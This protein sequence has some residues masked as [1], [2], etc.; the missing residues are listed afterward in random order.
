MNLVDVK[1]IY[2]LGIGGI[3][4]SALARYFLL[5]GKQV[6]GY[7]RTATPLT[8]QLEAEGAL[9]NYE[10]SLRHI[11]SDIDLVIF[12]PAIPSDSRQ[13]EYIRQN[14]IPLYKRARIL[15]MISEGKKVIAVAGTHGKTTVTTILAHIFKRA[16]ADFMAFLGGIST[17]YNTNFIHSGEPRWVIA[18]A[19]E[20]DRS[21]LQL[22]PDVAIV[23]SM[24]ADHLDVYG[25]LTHLEDSF[26]LF[27][28]N[29]KQDGI[30]VRHAHLNRLKENILQVSY[31]LSQDADY[32]AEDI[33]VSEGKYSC[34]FNLKGKK[35]PVNFGWA[36]RHNLE[37]ALAATAASV[38]AGIPAQVIQK[39]LIGFKGVK[40]RFEVIVQN[41]KVTYIDD[42]AHHPEEIRTCLSS[43][44]EMFPGKKLTGIFQPHLFSRTRDFAAEFGKA[45]SILDEVVLMDIYPARELPIKDVTSKIIFD[46]IEHENKTLVRDDQLLEYIRGNNFEVLITLGAGDIDKYVESIKELL[47]S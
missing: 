31:A 22:Y 25:S 44:R 35:L 38:H 46:N 27:V 47:N 23:T 36:G 15:G 7:D 41:Q 40:R 32:S 43:A 12:T 10:D 29:I 14:E 39:A 17:N 20:Y 42:Y 8:R 28:G 4:M 1:K 18:E 3:G 11:P 13:L 37:N 33:R 24:D 9:V 19:D 6:A 16:G 5:Q 2:F 45:L 26:R 21:F 34:T 30:L